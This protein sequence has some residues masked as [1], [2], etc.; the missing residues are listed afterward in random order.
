[1]TRQDVLS[2]Y[3]H[4]RAISRRHHSA[5]LKFLARSA[6]LEHARHLGMLQGQ[7]VIAN[8]DEE[9]TLIYDLAIHTAREGRSRA[10]DRYARSAWLPADSDE[11]AMLQAMCRARFSLWRI[12]RQHDTC[13]LVLDDLL[14]KTET[15]LV[16]EGL[17]MSGVSGGC[18]AA[19][20]YY[21]DQYAITS[22]A[23]APV[24]RSVLQDAL[25]DGLACRRADPARVADDPRFAAAIYRAAMNNGIMENVVFA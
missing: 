8:S 17:E 15:W 10:I 7:T 20:L 14:R 13:G 5:A 11:M 21:A 24:D 19:R 25:N 12:A 3:R 16:D 22:G 6:I 23:I 9:L 1:M 4:L 2:R 18:F